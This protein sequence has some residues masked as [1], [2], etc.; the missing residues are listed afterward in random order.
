M[1]S[2]PSHR[3]TQGVRPTVLMT[4]MRSLMFVEYDHRPLIRILRIMQVPIMPS[5]PRHDHHIESTRGDDGKI[6]RIQALQ[7]FTA[8]QRQPPSRRATLPAPVPQLQPSEWHSF[9]QNTSGAYY[10]EASVS[11]HHLLTPYLSS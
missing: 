8:E 10:Q 3:L 11:S 7:V 2:N 9:Q 6:L 5:V 1:L 4:R